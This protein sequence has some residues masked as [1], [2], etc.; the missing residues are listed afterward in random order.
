VGTTFFGHEE[1]VRGDS[2]FFTIRLE[3]YM[4]L[5]FAAI[6][7]AT[8]IAGPAFADADVIT[9]NGAYDLATQGDSDTAG[10]FGQ[11]EF[12]APTL[13][14]KVTGNGAFIAQY[15]SDNTAYI[16]QGNSG[17][18]LKNVAFIV[19]GGSADTAIILQTTGSNNQALVWQ[20]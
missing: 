20:H 2:P 19:Q 12:E 4:K 5:K 15:G 7:L 6:A 14:A 17:T 10:A 11:A 8:L 16:E 1:S 9:I 18:S 3:I 13:I